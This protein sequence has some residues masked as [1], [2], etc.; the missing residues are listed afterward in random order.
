LNSKSSKYYVKVIEKTIK[1]PSYPEKELARLQSIL[2]KG[3]TSADKRD[4][5]QRRANVL[6]RFGNAGHE[7]L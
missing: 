5:F 2:A 6:K 7:E 3:N 1:N 4:D